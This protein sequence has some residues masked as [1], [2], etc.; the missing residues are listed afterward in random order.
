MR[1]DSRKEFL[2]PEAE[3]A[4]IA[5]GCELREWI[6]WKQRFQ[7]LQCTHGVREE[8]EVEFLQIGDVVKGFQ[9]GV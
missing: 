7:G 4:E 2:C 3:V 6:D 8:H 9:V 5:L 1:G